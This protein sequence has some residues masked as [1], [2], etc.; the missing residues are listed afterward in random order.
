MK[1]YIKTVNIIINLIQKADLDE[2]SEKLIKIL[3][4]YVKMDKNILKFNETEI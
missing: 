1:V 4:A 2:K 3:K